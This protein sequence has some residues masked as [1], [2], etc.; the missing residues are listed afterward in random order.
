MS[1]DTFLD[2]E[3]DKISVSNRFHVLFY[4]FYQFQ[5]CADITTVF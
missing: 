5:T 2:F 1:L 3:R 4:L